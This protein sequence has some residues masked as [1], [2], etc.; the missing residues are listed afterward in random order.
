V[1][2]DLCGCDLCCCGRAV[3]AAVPAAVAV[4]TGAANLSRA[5]ANLSRSE[6]TD[7]VGGRKLL[8]C[9]SRSDLSRSDSVLDSV[10]GGNLLGLGSHGFLG[11]MTGDDILVLLFLNLLFLNYCF[12]ITVS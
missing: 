6:L 10:G 5:A 3:P 8:G 7:S 11:G 2:G 12:L 1:C 4:G 9:L